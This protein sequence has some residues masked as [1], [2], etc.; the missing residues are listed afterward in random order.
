[1]CISVLKVDV[2]IADCG[3]QATS[4]RIA[5]GHWKAAV[6]GDCSV[7]ISPEGIP[8][9]PFKV[10]Y[11][12]FSAKVGADSDSALGWGMCLKLGNIE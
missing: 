8:P 5:A 4:F 6:S 7:V 10:R 3:Y 12:G 9:W 2:G 1:M 11:L